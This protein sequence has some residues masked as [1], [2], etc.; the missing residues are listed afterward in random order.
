MVGFASH[1]IFDPILDFVDVLDSDVSDSDVSDSDLFE[2]LSQK[3]LYFDFF[4]YA[5][6]P[7]GIQSVEYAF[8]GA[9]LFFDSS[10]RKV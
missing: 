1:Y 3:F 9:G 7:F 4:C 5:R 6:F 2:I 8:S 10:S